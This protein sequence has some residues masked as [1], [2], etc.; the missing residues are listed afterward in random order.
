MS[1]KQSVDAGER[2]VQ[3]LVILPADF[4]R[5]V[6]TLEKDLES[7]NLDTERLNKLLRLYKTAEIYYSQKADLKRQNEY[8]SKRKFA[9][10]L[11]HVTQLM[12]AK[13]ARYELKSDILSR[14][15]S[16]MRRRSVVNIIVEEQKEKEKEKATETIEQISTQLS[17]Q[18]KLLKSDLEKQADSLQKRLA[19]RSKKLLPNLTIPTAGP[20]QRLNTKSTEPEDT[21]LDMKS[22]ENFPQANFCTQSDSN[23]LKELNRI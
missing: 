7:K 2:R 4:S 1:R 22:Y 14:A 12:N 5:Q 15:T 16:A 17:E 3:V 10:N 13:T 21:D 9:L 19:L 23:S 11:P 18:L 20:E 8:V 6:S